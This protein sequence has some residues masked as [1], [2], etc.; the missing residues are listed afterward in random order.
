MVYPDNPA[1]VEEIVEALSKSTGLAVT[2]N[3]AYGSLTRIPDA[4][5]MTRAYYQALFD[6]RL[7]YRLV[8]D[9]ASY[10]GLG[11]L[12][13]ADDW[14]EEAFTVYDHPRVL[15]FRKTHDF[16]PEQVRAVLM[17]ALPQPAP[18]LDEWDKWPRSRKRTVAPVAPPSRAS[19]GG[20][21]QIV[22]AATTGS[23]EA[24][25]W[26]YLA[27]S[28]LGLLA[29]PVTYGLFSRLGD[30]GFGFARLL[31]LI[32]VTYSSRAMLW[33]G[34]FAGAS[35][36]AWLCLVL[37]SLVSLVAFL[38][39]RADFLA[40]VRA[41]R[42]AL[43]RSEAVFAAGF[44]FFIGCRALNPEIYW[45]E[46]PMDLSILNI[47]IRSEHLPPPDP[48]FAGV[49]FAYYFFGQETI[50]VLTALSGLPTRFTYNLAFGFLGG[51][52]LQGAFAL[53]SSWGL[54]VRAGVAG[55]VFTLLIGN[56]AGLREWLVEGRAPGWDY[57]WATSRVIRGTIN[58]TRSGVCSLQT[59]TPTC[60]PSPCCCWSLPRFS[61]CSGCTASPARHGRR[62]SARPVSS[63]LSPACTR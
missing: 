42:R 56:L 47:L 60:W 19:G 48:W 4:F 11:P 58:D 40:F 10:P 53:A 18:T 34:A 38:R 14:A 63:D 25:L 43:V 49:P 8:A 39:R 52:V 17:A 20:A 33:T 46:K 12:T 30:R 6:G 37:L 31:G 27:C 16:T 7:G 35:G 41:Q 51:V 45:G 13:I 50:A 62:G 15:L 61:S 28:L 44:L 59:S 57:F 2:S 36:A 9:V 29:F 54:R 26:F 5:P 23:A 55:A 1:K 21:A 24:V 3:R 32:A 22:P